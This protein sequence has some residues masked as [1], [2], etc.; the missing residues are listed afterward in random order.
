M[1]IRNLRAL[2]FGVISVFIVWET[3]KIFLDL[4]GTTEIHVQ[5]FMSVSIMIIGAK[6]AGAGA[7]VVFSVSL[8]HSTK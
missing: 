7:P 3:L 5:T 6:L 1:L 2:V 8:S 4:L